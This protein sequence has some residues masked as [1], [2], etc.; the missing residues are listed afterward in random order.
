MLREENVALH[1]F[2]LRIFFFVC[3]FFHSGALKTKQSSYVGNEWQIRNNNGSYSKFL[4]A[5]ANKFFRKPLIHLKNLKYRQ[6]V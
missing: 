1:N 4:S 3:N 6:Y 5:D 2:F